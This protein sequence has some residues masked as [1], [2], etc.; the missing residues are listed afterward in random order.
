MSKSKDTIGDIKMRTISIS[1][2]VYG[3]LM[4]VL[5]IISGYILKGGS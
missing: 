5:G 4:F 2:L 1:L 3:L